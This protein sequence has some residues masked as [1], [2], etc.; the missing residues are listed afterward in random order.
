MRFLCVFLSITTAQHRV[1]AVSP[2][3]LTPVVESG[4]DPTSGSATAAADWPCWRGPNQ[5]NR[6]AAATPPVYWKA[7][8][9]IAWK[10]A[11]PGRGHASP[12]LVGDQIFIA[13]ADESAGTQFLLC[14]RRSD[15]MLLWQAPVRAGRLPHRH[16][17]NSHASA[18]P[19]C[20]GRL[21]VVVFANSDRLWVSGVSV[22]GEL[23]WQKD[24][25]GFR[26]ANGYGPSPAMH[27]GL[28]IVASDN[29]EQ[30]LIAALRFSDGETVWQVERP[31]SDNSA[32]PV[33]ADV[34]GRPQLLLNGAFL[35][36]GYDPA[37][38]AELWRVTH[39]TEVAANTMAFDGELVFASG[40]VPEKLL[41]AVRADGR[42]DV[43]ASN[44]AWRT[45]HAN[46]YVPSPL[47]K[48]G[49]L[50]T[51]L[52]AGTVVCRDARTGDELWTKR[53]GGTFFASPVEAAGL[54]YAANDTGTTY[55][56]RAGRVFE[57][58]AEN[59]LDE[60]CFATPAICGNRIY[61]R[62]TSHLICIGSNDQPHVKPP[63][64]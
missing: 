21:V 63:V 8:E 52:D 54:I 25:G 46:P 32:T 2:T 39:K 60:A 34:A 61:L 55:V 15:G 33:V 49:L 6:S 47:L 19:A 1:L 59:R 40:N 24:I 37:T 45:H 44:I 36:A 62:T 17:N 26:H 14:Y 53:L 16:P 50:F 9:N 28:A 57:S 42:G 41:M 11:V 48:D 5:N 22:A 4:P 31:H 7:D 10:V 13:T 3:T 38:G 27:G 64:E 29:Q 51:I 35:T 56:F 12:C 43:T 23:L 30:P 58:I 20:D 18:T